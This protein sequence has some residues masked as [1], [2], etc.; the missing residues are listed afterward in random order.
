MTPG[1]GVAIFL[2]IL[3]ILLAW[4]GYR[5]KSM[6]PAEWL[7][8]AFV[9]IPSVELFLLLQLGS[10]MGPTATFAL[11]II[12]SFSASIIL[13]HPQSPIQLGLGTLGLILLAILWRVP[14][15]TSANK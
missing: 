2:G 5:K 11:I 8:L 12:I 14:E 13:L 6:I 1:V 10:L 3:A 4:R 15:Q 9:M 7:F